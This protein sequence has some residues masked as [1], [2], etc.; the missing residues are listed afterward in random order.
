MCS[1]ACSQKGSAVLSKG[2]SLCHHTSAM[3]SCLSILQLKKLSLRE[4]KRFCF[5]RGWGTDWEGRGPD[6]PDA[7]AHGSGQDRKA[8]WRR[9]NL[10][11]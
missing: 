3:G 7:R 2:L 4:A 5:G 11:G 10:I 8:S 1:H 9:W 6:M